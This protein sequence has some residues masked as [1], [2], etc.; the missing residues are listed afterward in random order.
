M[1]PRKRILIQWAAIA[2]GLALLATALVQAGARRPEKAAAIPGVGQAAPDFVLPDLAGE[3]VGLARYRG[4]FVLLGFWVSWCPPCREE[5]PSLKKLYEDFA[6]RDLV[7]L[8]VNAG[9]P[10]E[11][12][13]DFVRREALT[14]PVLLDPDGRVQERYGAYQFPVFFLIDREGRIAA[15]YLGLRDWTSSVVRQE[16]AEKM[17]Q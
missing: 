4:K 7:L 2:L 13:A 9:E 11:Q 6:G 16:L 1:K 14:F 5:M 15:R 8:A 10:S 17:G 3:E 12:V